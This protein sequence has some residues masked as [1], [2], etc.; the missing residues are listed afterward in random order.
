M[1]PIIKVSSKNQRH[2]DTFNDKSL[3]LINR[4]KILEVIQSFN[5]KNDVTDLTQDEIDKLDDQLQIIFDKAA[6]CTVRMK[7]GML[8]NEE[9]EK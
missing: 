2:I 1:V 7:R 5:N 6:S 4:K 3:E 8:R 9:T